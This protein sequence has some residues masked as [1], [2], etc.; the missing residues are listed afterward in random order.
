MG[1]LAKLAPHPDKPDYNGAL[2]IQT[3][4]YFKPPAEYDGMMGSI[5]MEAGLSMTFGESAGNVIDTAEAAST[6]YQD[7]KSTVSHGF[8]QAS[9][10]A[11]AMKT[12]MR[13]LPRRL[14]L[15]GHIATLQ[16]KYYAMLKHAQTYAT[17]VYACV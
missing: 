3:D 17:P 6:I 13:D 16:R 4:S 8:N 5:L 9:K 14:R 10:R 12:Y 7:R 2:F 15:E 1:E 11:C